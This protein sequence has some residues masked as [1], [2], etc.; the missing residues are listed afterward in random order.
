[1]ILVF[2]MFWHLSPG[3]RELGFTVKK[4]ALFF[5][6]LKSGPSVVLTVGE[7]IISAFHQKPNNISCMI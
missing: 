5:E 6:L 4:V 1:M 3:G 2:H 7:K